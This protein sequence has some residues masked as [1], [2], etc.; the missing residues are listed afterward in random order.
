MPTSEEP[1]P[2]NLHRSQLAPDAFAEYCVSERERRRNAGEG[3]DPTL[4]DETV[5]LVLKKL[6]KLEQEG[7]A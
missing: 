4:F 3:F 7:S 1:R 5:E 2:L 6:R